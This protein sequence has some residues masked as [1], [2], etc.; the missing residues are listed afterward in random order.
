MNDAVVRQINA[1]IG[2]ND[3]AYCLGDWSFGSLENAR[4]FREKINC[5]NVHLILGNHD[6]RHGTQIN[7][8][9]PNSQNHL[10]MHLFFYDLFESVSNYKEFYYNKTLFCLFHYP[11]SSWNKMSDGSICLFGHCH[12]SPEDRF[13]NGGKS[14]DIGIDGGGP[15]SVDEIMEIMEDRP[16]KR[17]GHHQ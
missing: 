15:Y 11:I 6:N 16:I 1:T 3:T 8:I 7:P 10:G 9:I 17:E 5:E 13:F 14:M 2:K 12:S 4:I